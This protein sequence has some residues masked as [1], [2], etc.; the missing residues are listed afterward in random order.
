MFVFKTGR[1]LVPSCNNSFIL[2]KNLKIMEIYGKSSGH[3]TRHNS[4]GWF[5]AETSF[6]LPSTQ[7]FT[8]FRN[9]NC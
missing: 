4:N 3:P 6:G 1:M 7:N 9:F 2:Y 5:E 8:V